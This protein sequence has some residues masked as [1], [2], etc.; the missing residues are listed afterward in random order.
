M[1]AI[2]WHGSRT[3]VVGKSCESSERDAIQSKATELGM[4]D[5]IC[6]ESLPMDR[7]HNAKLDY[8]ALRAV[9]AKTGGH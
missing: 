4:E 2:D 1:A 6:L 7:R 8:P 5:L 9:L 3:L